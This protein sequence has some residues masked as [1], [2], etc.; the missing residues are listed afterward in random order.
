MFGQLITNSLAGRGLA[1]RRAY[2]QEATKSVKIPYIKQSMEPPTP[3]TATLLRLQ[4]DL[5]P[6]GFELIG[7]VF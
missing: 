5:L 1:T 3:P 6:S 2:C 7:L 4:V